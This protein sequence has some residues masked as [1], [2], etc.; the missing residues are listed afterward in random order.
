[1]VDDFFRATADDGE[2]EAALPSRPTDELISEP[3]SPAPL[4]SLAS[5]PYSEN[6]FAASLEVMNRS[7]FDAADEGGR[8][9]REWFTALPKFPERERDA[10]RRIAAV[11]P[12]LRSP[13]LTE[14]LLET[15][16]RLTRTS[17]EADTWMLEPLEVSETDLDAALLQNPPEHAA[18]AVFSVEPAADGRA[19]GARLG[20][21]CGALF[22]RYLISL[23]T[24]D[25]AA[26]EESRR[27]APVWPDEATTPL[28]V[29]PFS[30]VELAVFE[31]ILLQLAARVNSSVEA[32]LLKLE[33]I[34]APP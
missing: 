25:D 7:A 6:L 21:T 18:G 33:T 32:P 28:A 15:L 19:D 22:A 11:L 20:C 31:F 3:S 27:N 4:A 14:D 23:L 5:D 34:V 24:R 26:E 1:M 17:P 16:A 29:R 13:Q 8:A 30:V 9:G 10:A 12:A 2:A